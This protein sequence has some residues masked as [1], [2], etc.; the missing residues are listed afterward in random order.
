MKTEH[1]LAR[2]LKEMMSSQPL[3]TIS[4]MDLSDKCGVSRKTFYYHY[5]DIYDLLTQ[6]FLDEKILGN[7]NIQNLDDIIEAVWKYYKENETF[8]SATLSSA[9]KDLFAEYVYNSF[10]TA[11][12]KLVSHLDSEKKLP[13]NTRKNIARFYASGYSNS[14][15]YYLSNYKSKSLEGL[16]SCFSFLTNINIEKSVQKAIKLLENDKK[17]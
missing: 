17:L 2:T 7:A 3:D 5:H 15:V 1:A 16:K 8:V 6:V 4:V 9:G 14:V 13:I 11:S 12:M 10:Y